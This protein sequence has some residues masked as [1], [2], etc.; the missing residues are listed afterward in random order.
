MPITFN[1]LRNIRSD[2]G[3]YFTGRPEHLR[4]D[5][6]QLVRIEQFRSRGTV[7]FAEMR[8]WVL[9]RSNDDTGNVLI[10]DRCRFALSQ[11][12]GSCIFACGVKIRKN[13]HIRH[14]R[15]CGIPRCPPLAG[16]MFPAVCPAQPMI[17]W[18][19]DRANSDS[20]FR[21]THAPTNALGPDGT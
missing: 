18:C 19:S 1:A 14:D 15:T 11:R 13:S 12:C 17:L 7:I 5:P 20:V 8:C 21:G 4:I 9:Q 3:W 10:R 6:S 2:N 16:R